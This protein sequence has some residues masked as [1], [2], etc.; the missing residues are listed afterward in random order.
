MNDDIFIETRNRDDLFKLSSPTPPQAPKDTVVED[1]DIF[2]VRSDDRRG[3][4][5]YRTE[6]VVEDRRSGEDEEVIHKK[7]GFEDEEVIHK[8]GGFED[9]EIDFKNI[10]N[11]PDLM[12]ILKRKTKVQSPIPD[13]SSDEVVHRRVLKL[14]NRSSDVNYEKEH[15]KVR[16]SAMEAFFIK[17][18]NLKL[19][20]PEHDITFPD[21]KS[22]NL[23]HKHYHEIIKS[24][25]VSMNLGQTQLCYVLCLMVLEFVAVKALGLPMAG[26]TK[27][28]LRRM[29]KYHSLMIELG[30]SMYS[31]GEGGEPQPVEWRIASTFIWNI[32]I[33]LGIKI[34][35]N[36]LENENL[37]ETIRG[38]VDKLFET[39]VNK[40]DIESGEAK[41][42]NSEGEEL[43][44]GL[45]G[46]GFNDLINLVSNIGSGVTKGMENRQRKK[47][48]VKKNRFIFT[49]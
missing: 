13:Y 3:P 32:V 46:G 27:M 44:S 48:P 5:T 12:D 39:N 19:H 49:E 2:D 28:E 4:E 15:E 23:I 38:I 45:S 43:L 47:G 16:E 21:N 42:I 31:S 14:I 22:L 29:E 24:I 10:L 25:Y 34:A 9:E 7:G 36:Y 17:Y 30:E 35:S 1:E 18:Q 20:Y 37:V 26:F 40:D 41:K 6:D 33:F 8:K 11:N